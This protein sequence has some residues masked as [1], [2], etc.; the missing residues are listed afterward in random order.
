LL[1]PSNLDPLSR[2]S[3]Q[4]YAKTCDLLRH[5]EV[6]W[7]SRGKSLSSVFELHDELRTFLISHSYEYAT[8]LTD[9]SWVAKL[10]YLTE[11][12]SP[13]NELNRKMQ[14]EDETVFITTDKI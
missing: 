12:F 2:A 5:T 3:F 7:L 1:T 9:E 8:L 10:A 6:S 11:I 4:P 13:I 14:G